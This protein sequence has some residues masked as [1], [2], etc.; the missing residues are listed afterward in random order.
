MSGSGWLQLVA[1]VAVVAVAAPLL[2][3]YLA[4]VHGGGRAPG[5]RFFA[6]IERATYR[7]LGVDPSSGQRWSGYACSMVVFG[8][9]STMVLFAVLRVQHLLPLNPTDAPSVPPAM[10]FNTAV[11]FVTGTNWQAYAGESTMSHL[12]QTAGLVVTQFTAAA[13]GMSVAVA[14]VRGLLHRRRDTAEGPD[15]GLLGNFWVDVVRNTLRVLQPIAVVATVAMISAG[16]VQNLRGNTEASTVEG[17]TQL[18]PGGLVASQEVMKTL[19][20]NGGGFYNVGSAHPFANP[21]G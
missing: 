7:L 2:A 11:S 18:I 4:A 9:V 20:T 19:G 17:T 3:R 14:V 5:D 12:A 13:V 10:A 15:P 16:S 6:P 8:A 21:T 1:M